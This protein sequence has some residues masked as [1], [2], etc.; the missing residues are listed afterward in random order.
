MLTRR[1]TLFRFRMPFVRWIFIESWM[2]TNA[3]RT[4]QWLLCYSLIFISRFPPFTHSLSLSL[5]TNRP[6]FSAAVLLFFCY[7]SYFITLVP[8]E[9]A[10]SLWWW[11]WY[12]WY[13]IFS[14]I[15]IPHLV[16]HRAQWND[17]LAFLLSLFYYIII[18]CASFS[19]F[20][21]FSFL[22]FFLFRSLSFESYSRSPIATHTSTHP[23]SLSLTLF[24]H[25]CHPMLALTLTWSAH[26]L[27]VWQSHS[28]C[29]CARVRA[30][31][32][33]LIFALDNFF[34]SMRV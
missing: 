18:F 3:A 6:P 10:F 19:L 22:F 16:T 17:S 5:S 29:E 11:Y 32:N 33:V 12:I 15:I 31:F 7:T 25:S 34:F 9:F 4:K 14:S 26:S 21:F 30:R 1:K 27:F 24:S 23:A 8:F 2:H 20:A 13:S 28:H